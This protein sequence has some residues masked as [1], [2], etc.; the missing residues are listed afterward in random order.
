MPALRNAFTRARTRLSPTRARTRS[1]RGG[2]E[3]SAG[4]GFDVALHDPLVFLGREVAH[5]GY[6]VMGPAAGAEPVGTREEIRLKNR[7]QRQFQGRLH[8][9][10]GDRRDPQ[11]AQLA[12]GLGD[13][14]LPHRHGLETAVFEL[15]PQYAEELPGP[16]PQRD[17]RRRAPVHPGRARALVAP[18]PVPGHQQEAGIGNEV[19][20]VAEPAM[21][22]ITG[23]TVQLGLD[24]QYPALR[25]IQGVLQLVGVHRRPPGIPV[26][27]PRTCWPPSPCGR[28][29]RPPR[30]AVTPATTTGPPPHP[31][32]ISR[33]RACPPPGWL[34]S[35]PG[36]R[37]WFPR[38]PRTRSAREAP[39]STPA[40]SPR[41][42]RRPSAWPPHRNR[43]PA[44]ELTRRPWTDT[45]R[46]AHW[47]VSTRF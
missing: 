20:Q 29:S 8:D 37:G 27:Q 31:T 32:A 17:G 13:H 9:P 5:L 25:L 30:R 36:G 19:E 26:R 14:P 24:L 1:M 22:I 34:P 35:G 12:A 40:A 7:L 33:P 15:R 10:A 6:R 3:I 38:S 28:L 16:G 4:A 23:P 41:L 46:T 43:N 42:R 44:S 21:R 45:S 39:S 11:A 47:P 2:C 18:H